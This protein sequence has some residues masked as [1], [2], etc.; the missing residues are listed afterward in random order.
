[1]ASWRRTTYLGFR[2]P[3]GA[4]LRHVVELPGGVGGAARLVVQGVQGRGAGALAGLAAGAAVPV[5]AP[6]CQQHAVSGFAGLPG[7][8]PGVVGS[9]AFGAVPV[10]G[11]GGAAG[12]SG[13]FDGDLR[14]PGDVRRDLL[15][16]CW[17][18]GDWGDAGLRP[19]R[20]R[21]AGARLSEEGSGAP[22][23]PRRGEGVGRAGRTGVLGLRGGGA[24]EGGLASQ[25]VQV[26]AGG[27]GVPQAAGVRHQ[28][29]TVLAIALTG[30]LARVRG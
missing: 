3:F 8:E 6:D 9:G 21:L 13:S 10:V 5:A 16:G 4:A 7:S 1:M 19:E 23:A 20:R 18:D 30:K 28:L 2:S 17:L 12:A 14:G 27:A 25:P 26:P 15:P 22:A 29:A 24:A 11:H